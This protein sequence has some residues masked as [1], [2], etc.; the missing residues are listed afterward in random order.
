MK[1]FKK[2]IYTLLLFAGIHKSAV[3]QEAAIDKEL[4]K[5]QDAYQSRDYLSFN[6]QYL[7]SYFKEPETYI[8][9]VY[10]SYKLSKNKYWAKMDDVEFIQN[11]SLLIAVYP[12][13]RVLLINRAVP[14]WVDMISNWEKLWQQQKSKLQAAVD[15]SSATGKIVL[16]Y[17]GDSIYK[18]VEIWYNQTTFLTER[19]VFVIKQPQF[20]MED[21]DEEKLSDD[22]SIIE[23]R[24]TAYDSKPFEPFIFSTANYINTVNGKVTPSSKYK[25][26]TILSGAPTK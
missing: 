13:D 11:D 3:A 20:L 10:G 9:T 8:D 15:K 5:I 25:E 17:T 26:Y 21:G 6:V 2:I 23:V 19:L 16:N 12:E 24:L 4:K 22:F 7:Y 18:R 1:G 14:N